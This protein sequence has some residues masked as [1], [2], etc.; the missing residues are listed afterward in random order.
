[1]IAHVTGL[2]HRC[3]E[4]MQRLLEGGLS[5]TETLAGRTDGHALSR[6]DG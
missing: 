2:F 3:F 4:Q 5:I 1:M 6:I